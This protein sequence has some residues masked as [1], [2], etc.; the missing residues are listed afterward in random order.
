MPFTVSHVAAV[1]PLLRC[2]KLDPLA[3]VIGSMA[4][5]FGYY[6]HE[7]LLAS[8]AHDSR[9][10]FLVALPMAWL[11]WL[12][13]KAGARIVS[14]PLPEPDRGLLLGFLGTGSASPAWLWVTVSLLLGIWSHNVLDAFTHSGGWVVRRVSWLHTPWPLFHVLQ[15]M[16]S[17][18]GMAVL[19]V[20][21]SLKRRSLGPWIWTSKHTVLVSGAVLCAFVA[22]PFAWSLT[23]RFEGWFFIRALTFRWIVGALAFASLAYLILGALLWLKERR[24]IH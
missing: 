6:F 7:F 14:A 21:Y 12:L 18:S 4:P 5:D 16:G 8:R 3:L 1:V 17:I 23:S 20:V 9:G 13:V 11:A 24:A 2:R 10:S 19:I 22:L 15:H